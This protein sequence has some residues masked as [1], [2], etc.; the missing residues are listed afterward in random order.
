MQ[1][2]NVQLNVSP[3]PGDISPLPTMFAQAHGDGVFG[4]LDPQAVFGLDPPLAALPP[5]GIAGEAPAGLP[6][7]PDL[8]V[9]T[10]LE[11]N[12]VPKLIPNM[13]PDLE[14]DLV[15]SKLILIRQPLVGDRL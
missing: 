1:V 7:Q 13:V 6:S 11:P 4:H 14:L 2:A 9:S 12:L 5:P 10:Y 8:Q 3:G 15:P